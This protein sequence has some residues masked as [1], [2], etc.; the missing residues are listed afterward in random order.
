MILLDTHSWV[1]VAAQSE[2]LSQKAIDEYYRA[3]ETKAVYIS[4]I[5][6]WE[7][8]LLSSKGRIRLPDSPAALLANTEQDDAVS[9]VPIDARIARLA[10]EL[11]D[12]HRDPADRMILATAQEMGARVVSKDERLREYRVAEVV[13]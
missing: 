8:F 3:R 9:I 4:A 7:V 1:W 13:W 11:P 10:V 2:R 5:S 12:I 6:V